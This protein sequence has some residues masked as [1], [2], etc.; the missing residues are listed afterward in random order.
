MFDLPSAPLF[1]LR[2]PLP[3][4]RCQRAR[5]AAKGMPGRLLHQHYWSDL[6]TS[7]PFPLTLALLTQRQNGVRGCSEAVVAA[8]DA[9]QEPPGQELRKQLNVIGSSKNTS[10]VVGALFKSFGGSINFILQETGLD[11]MRRKQF[12]ITWTLVIFLRILIR[13]SHWQEG[14]TVK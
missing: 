8:A 10:P 7:S 5:S 9:R 4:D 1:H 14:K 13:Q 2:L 12:Q 6:I 3:R 11:E